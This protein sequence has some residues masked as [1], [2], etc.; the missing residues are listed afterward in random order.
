MLQKSA[1]KVLILVFS[2]SHRVNFIDYLKE[3]NI[4]TI[5]DK[6]CWKNTE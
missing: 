6:I 2:Y 1:E 3:G 4:L 5:V